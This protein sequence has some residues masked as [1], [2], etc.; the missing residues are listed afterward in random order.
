MTPD[1]EALR[2]MDAGSA[3]NTGLLADLEPFVVAARESLARFDRRPF[4]VAIAD[5]ACFD[6]LHRRSVPLLELL[7]RLDA[8]T[9]GPEGMPMPRWLFLDGAALPGAIVGLGR[10][11]H[12]ISGAV[13]A[14]LGVPDDHA[15]IVPCSMYIAMPS[16][17]EGAWVGHNLASLR[18]RLPTEPLRGLGGLTKAIALKV[19]RASTQLGMTQWDS[20]ALRVHARMGP[21]ALLT[22]WTPAHSEPAT[23][24]YRARLDDEVLRCLARDTSASLARPAPERWIDSADHAAMQALQARIEAGERLCVADIPE[25]VA[26]SGGARQRVPIAPMPDGKA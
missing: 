19:I 14:A 18:E 5:D 23:L 16:F 4:G 1:A 17:E 12:A 7:Y 15:G 8:A 6:P 3:G 22:A 21:L 26:G 9:F 13:R 10:R 11:S 24:T 20:R 25:P 2:L